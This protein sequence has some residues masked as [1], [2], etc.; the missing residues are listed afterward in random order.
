[1]ETSGLSPAPV[2]GRYGS[3]PVQSKSVPEL[4]VPWC[5]LVF[6]AMAFF[7]FFCAYLLRTCLNVAIVAMVNQTA[8]A[9]HTTMTN[10][11]E[12]RCPQEQSELRV[13]GGQFSWD[14]SQQGIVLS[15][16]YFGHVVTQVVLY[17]VGLFSEYFRCVCIRTP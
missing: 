3:T 9:G 11:S 13:E 4:Y 12:D 5:G 2:S 14:R 15:A 8:V 10:V 6:Y 16:F 17:C 1:M 7:G